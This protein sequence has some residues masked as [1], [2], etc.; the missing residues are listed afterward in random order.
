[1]RNIRNSKSLI[2]ATAVAVGGFAIVGTT[3]AT[4]ASAAPAVTAPT[5]TA[6]PT[7]I[8]TS[9]ATPT[10]MP[11]SAA[12]QLAYRFSTLDNAADV[13]FNQLLGI[14]NAGEIAGYF[15]SGAADHP[16]KGYKLFPPYG[17]G[18]YASENF[19]GS[20]QTQV[21]GLNDKGDTVGFWSSTDTASMVNDNFGFYRL[22][23]HNFHSVQFPT[24]DNASPPVDQLLGINDHDIAVGFYTNGQG[25][26]RGYTYNINT[27][28]FSRV[29]VP[30]YPT[31]TAGPTLTAAAINNN[32]DV[33]GFYTDK[34]G[35]TDAFL[36]YHH[37][38]FLT[39]DYPGASAT[40][41]FGVNDRDEVVGAYT[42]GT[43]SGA[44]MHGFT[45]T[46]GGGFA[47]VDDPHGIGATTINGVNDAGD[48][49]GFYVDAA[50]NTDG[51]LAT[52]AHK[53]VVNLNLMSMPEGTVSLSTMSD[54]ADVVHVTM[55]GLTPGSSH[56]VMLGGAMIGTLTA[57]ATGQASAR[58]VAGSIPNGAALKIL[59]GGTGTDKIATAGPLN[60]GNGG[61]YQLQAVESGFPAGSLQGHATLVYDP[62]AQTISVTLTAS[63]VS[64]GAH[65]AH[66]H[67]GSCQSQGPV[68][69]MLMDFTADGNGNINN[70]T[71]VV[72][73]VTTPLPASGWYLNLH[74]GDMDN[75]LSN[76]QPTILFRPL[77][78]ADI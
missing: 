9:T 10:A 3:L 25:N 33:A 20:V 28:Q 18:S 17:P 55:F 60:A 31:G 57:D 70:E 56:A 16:N 34:N 73:G 41:A 52:P 23:G 53:Q 74:Q 62:A 47:S 35:N 58:F 2:T 42:D 22:R 27:R 71:R 26:N 4:M 69:Y 51:F 46:P 45:W 5:A 40:Q 11:T 12:G 39:L 75:I 29:L 8:G 1:M 13:T 43:G 6:T 24:G 38:E 30:G 21:T 54:E 64:P 77:L 72:T 36:A 66:I 48:L 65:A 44:T 78:C 61:P 19:P 15:G 32:G 37:G 68:Q 49:V 7:A 76:G 14:N 67:L 50:G 59:D 63:G